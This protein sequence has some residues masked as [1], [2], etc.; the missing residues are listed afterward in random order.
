MKKVLFLLIFIAQA[1][2]SFSQLKGSS[3]LLTDKTGWYEG[4]IILEDGAKFSGLVNYDDKRGVVS[5]FDGDNTRPFTP[6]KVITFSYFDESKHLKRTFYSIE[7]EDSETNVL[8]PLFFEVLRDY[9]SFAF[10]L[11]TDPIKIDIKNRNLSGDPFA[12]GGVM[13]SPQGVK[14]KTEVSQTQTVYILDN[15]GKIKPYFKLVVR[16]D[17]ARSLLAKE[18]AEKK[19][20]MLDRDLLEEYVS[21]SDY[22]KLREY[23]KENDLQFKV[24]EDF[25]KILTYY[26]SIR[27]P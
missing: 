22:Q 20:S 4:E 24:R 13:N 10:V 23:A 27:T 19:N 18:D 15:N 7:D 21:K 3:D 25:M 14:S 17:G 12:P 11:R 1:F 5:Y 8:R 6:R 26:D 2:N 9:K 16:Q